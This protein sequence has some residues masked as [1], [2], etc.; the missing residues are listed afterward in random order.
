MGWLLAMSTSLVTDWV[1][2]HT[3][4]VGVILGIN[5][6]SNTILVWPVLCNVPRGQRYTNLTHIKWATHSKTYPIMNITWCKDHNPIKPC[7]RPIAPAE[8]SAHC[9]AHRCP[10]PSWRRRSTPSLENMGARRK[11]EPTWLWSFREGR[12]LWPD[13]YSVNWY[14]TGLSSVFWKPESF[15]CDMSWLKRERAFIKCHSLGVKYHLSGW[16]IASSQAK[17]PI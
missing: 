5:N 4:K 14:L 15:F 16:F 6:P 11:S 8:T 17:C 7:C 12:D 2:I 9:K 1:G 3:H 13:V 10:G